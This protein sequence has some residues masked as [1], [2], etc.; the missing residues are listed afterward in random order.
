MAEPK[1][2]R[3]EGMMCDGCRSSVEMILKLH[4]ESAQRDAG[5]PAATVSGGKAEDVA[6]L[7]AALAKGGFK[8]GLRDL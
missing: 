5:A 1:T 8:L 4:T 2:Y 6:A 7:N 3:V